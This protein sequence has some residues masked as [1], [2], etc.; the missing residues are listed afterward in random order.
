MKTDAGGVETSIEQKENS[1]RRYYID[2]R[3][4]IIKRTT[5]GYHM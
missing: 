2:Q 4:T 1:I 3:Q 5:T